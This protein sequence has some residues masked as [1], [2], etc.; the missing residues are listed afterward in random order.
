MINTLVVGP[1]L[2]CTDGMIIAG[3]EYLLKRAGR[4]P[5]EYLTISEEFGQQT[6]PITKPD[7][8]VVAGTPWVWDRCW[9]SAKYK[10]LQ[11]LFNAF[12]G[13][14]RVFLGAGSCLPL[15]S[16]DQIKS[17]LVNNRA[18]LSIFDGAAVFTRDKI[19]T[20]IIPG[21]SLAPC[22]AFFAL[23]DSPSVSEALGPVM[24]WYD[25]TKG[26]SR[27]S[28]RPGSKQLEEYLSRFKAEYQANKPAVYCVLPEERDLAV[29]IGLPMPTLIEDVQHAKILISNAA[30]I[31]SGRVHLA[32]PAVP[33][34]KNIELIA[35]DT[36]A[37]TLT[38]GATILEQL[39]V[40]SGIIT[41]LR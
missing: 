4:P 18:E 3:T 25:P 27:S 2:P 5:T 11:I 8:I 13:A 21:A 15:G 10:N 28:F 6:M 37:T 36:R 31:F 14:R 17:N 24:F 41:A 35:V 32:V 40:T 39:G 30:R 34:D 12:P 19:A 9:E 26:L 1:K 7:T 16:Q 22:P 23:D 20:E 33:L 29:K 38:D